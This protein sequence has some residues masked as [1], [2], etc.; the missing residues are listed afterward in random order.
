MSRFTT[1]ARTVEMLG[2]QQI[3]GIPTA[4]NE[5]FKNAHD[6]Y[7]DVV[8][9]DYYRPEQ[10]FV[11]RDD[12]LGMTLE[13][14]ENKWLALGTDSKIVSGEGLDE[15][16]KDL[17]LDPRQVLG[18]KGIGRLSIAA[19]GPQ[20][21]ILSRARRENGLHETV[22]AFVNWTMF[23]LPGVNIEDIEVPIQ[24]YRDGALPTKMDVQQM[25]SVVFSNLRDLKNEGN[26]SIAELIENQ[27]KEFV[28]DPSALRLRLDQPA[29]TEEGYGTHFYI[30]PV[31]ESLNPDIDIID[32][33][34][35][36]ILRRMLIGFTNTMVP[37]HP[38]PVI[39]A[40][41]RD[42]RSAEITD[43]IISDGEFF[44][45]DDFESADHRF[46]GEF[47]EYGQ[48]QGTIQIYDNEPITN[49][50][51][52]LDAHGTPT[53]CGPF[54]I[55]L[56]YIQGEARASR[57]PPEEFGRIHQ[58][59]SLFGGLYIYRDGIRVLP[60]GNQD[61]DFL[62]IE[63]RRNRSAAYYFFS[64]RRMFGV[65]DIG[66][67]NNQHLIEKAGREG[68][69]ENRAYRQFRSI[70]EN[71][72]V[73]VA[74]QFFREEGTEGS[75]FSQSREELGRRALAAR[76]R[77]QLVRVRRQ[78]LEDQLKQGF[79]L[80]SQ[81]K[82]E[83]EIKTLVS[84]LERSLGAASN[85]D[86][87]DELIG[88]VLNAE[89]TAR[90]SMSEIRQKYRIPEPRGVGLSRSL[91]RDLDTYHIE[92]A[93]LEKD[94]FAPAIGNIDSAVNEFTQSLD[95]QLDRRRRF[96]LG[97]TTAVQVARTEARTLSQRARAV[98]DETTVRVN[99][100]LRRSVSELE[101]TLNEILATVQQTDLT[102][103]PDADV[104]QLRLNLDYQIESVGQQKYDILE[105]ITEQLRNIVVEPDESGTMI[106][107]LDMAEVA[108]EEL[109]ALRERVETDLDLAQLGMAV[110]VI[111]HE[112]QATI[113]GVRDHLK[114]L[115]EWANLNQRLGPIYRGIQVN[116]DH[117]DGYL[118]LFTP[119][120]RRSRR[121]KV[122]IKGAEIAKFLEELFG[123]R[124]ERHGVTLRAYYG[125]RTHQF[126]SYPS[127]FYPVFVNLI[128][129]AIFWLQD[130][131]GPRVISLDADGD[132]LI[133]T[134]T[135]PGVALRDRSA[136]F[137]S[138][139]TRK[140]G[141]RGL[142]LHISRD[143]LR[144]EGYEL[145][146][147]EPSRSYGARFLIVPIAEDSE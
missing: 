5:L 12:G 37:D 25:V 42:H 97:S 29:L 39:K 14:F 58:K 122:I 132:T 2:R 56:A 119:L 6:A 110:E 47:D 78:T 79:E 59:L 129:N 96:D 139:F 41:F 106:T 65:I 57:L 123:L 85:I 118:N 38:D 61:H 71:F 117:L 121:S 102:Q 108:E 51:P 69:R 82:P 10:L 34:K 18:A 22:A 32:G 92:F 134:D 15:I 21:L 133:V 67:E 140:P 135:G 8:E 83:S 20:V 54:R 107:R 86:N 31:D 127:T 116:F 138:G 45:T 100:A 27:L 19:I 26:S 141:G 84:D 48:F 55:D 80:I 35:A 91:R 44:T 137:E 147:D 99:S 88:A 111:D 49:I 7:A 105:G 40:E 68:F 87:P 145:V 30:Q 124:L 131:N 115:K 89:D 1:R 43:Y 66:N 81:R 95:V 75:A 125:F 63:E 90:R 62:H 11:L 16:A 93:R 76:R 36:P 144:R 94:Q 3:A 64:Y 120:H 23:S 53:D 33:G 128:D 4:I 101:Q 24:T 114:E 70:L 136:I 9:V 74:A 112:F 142:G 98:L 104:V 28:A 73:Q 46:R 60:Y 17:G 50:V 109:L 130:R 146:L 13:D 143:V 103:M 126:T 77:E 72:L 113:K 52:W